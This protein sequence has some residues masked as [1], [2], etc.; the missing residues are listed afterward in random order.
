MFIQNAKQLLEIIKAG[1]FIEAVDGLIRI[2]PAH[3]IDD[4][5]ASLVRAYKTELFELLNDKKTQ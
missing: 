4:E 3:S 5:M 1:Y 2:S